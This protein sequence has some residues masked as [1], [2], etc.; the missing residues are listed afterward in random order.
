MYLKL[1]QGTG[2]PAGRILIRG[3]QGLP[4]QKIL[5][6]LLKK[7]YYVESKFNLSCF[8]QGLFNRQNIWMLIYKE[9]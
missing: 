7:I 8:F 1:K 9:T 5:N 4:Q 2:K 6:S 3:K